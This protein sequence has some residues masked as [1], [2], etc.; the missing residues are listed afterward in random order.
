[1]Q[2]EIQVEYIHFMVTFSKTTLGNSLKVCSPP[3]SFN[4]ESIQIPNFSLKV[5]LKNLKIRF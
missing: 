4:N 3:F 2:D 5:H 1:M